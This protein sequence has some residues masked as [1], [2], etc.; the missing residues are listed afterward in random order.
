METITLNQFAYKIGL[1]LAQIQF[2]QSA[3]RDRAD[4][5]AFKQRPTFRILLGVFLIAFSFVA[6]WPAIIALGAI[7]NH[8]HMLTLGI[9]G[10]PILYGMSHVWF[11]LG[12]ALS[13]AEFSLIFLRWAAR[14]GVEKLLSFGASD[15][16]PEV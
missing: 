10:G 1:R 6:C 12:M 5:E 4:L 14:V 7:S 3:I 2:V 8:F 16:T 9:V 11:L 13:G 15:E